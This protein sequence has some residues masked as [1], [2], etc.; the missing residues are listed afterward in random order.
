MAGYELA[1]RLTIRGPDAVYL[2]P[3]GTRFTYNSAAWIAVH[4][5]KG[6]TH[7]Y[8][9]G[10]AHQCGRS[11]GATSDRATHRLPCHCLPVAA[12]VGT[13]TIAAGVW[14]MTTISPPATALTLI[15][16][17]LPAARWRYIP[18]GGWLEVFLPGS[19]GRGGDCRADW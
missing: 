8:Y 1:V 11:L 3:R 9:A 16:E 7:G 10:E 15:L 13:A 12:C 17:G 4:I 6:H 2:D 5:A 19:E 18:D 14:P